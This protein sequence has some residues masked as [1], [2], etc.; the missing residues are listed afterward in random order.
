[1]TKEPSK[2]GR[3]ENRMTN[4]YE[5]LYGLPG[6]VPCTV[7]VTLVDVQQCQLLT[8]LVLE[9]HTHKHQTLLSA[10]LYA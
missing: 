1:M 7:I 2:E 10:A 8:E 9:H 3:I 5:C 6:V 4:L